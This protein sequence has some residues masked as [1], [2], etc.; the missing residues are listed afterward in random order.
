MRWQ[1]AVRTAPAYFAEDFYIAA[2]AKSIADGVAALDFE[3]DVILTSYHGMPK[4]YLER[5]DPYHCQCLKT[6]RLV[7]EKL[8]LAG[9]TS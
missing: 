9:E 1:P 8:G 2:L 5:G 6:T 3:P 7:R 4:V